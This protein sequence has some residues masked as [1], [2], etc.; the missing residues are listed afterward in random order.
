LALGRISFAT[1]VLPWIVNTE[2]Q[3]GDASRQP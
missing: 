3:G 1:I 2:F